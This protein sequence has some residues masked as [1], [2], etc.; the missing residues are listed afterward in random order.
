[1]ELE[2]KSFKI[3]NRQR[4]KTIKSKYKKLLIGARKNISQIEDLI[5]KK[6]K[7]EK[8][9]AQTSSRVKNIYSIHKKL[10]KTRNNY[11]KIQDLL[12]IRIIA[13][14]KEACY[15]I[16]GI[17]HTLYQPIPNRFSDYIALPK[18]NGYQSIHTIVR[19]NNNLPLEFQIRTTEMDY[20][21]NF[22][23]ASHFVYTDDLKPKEDKRKN[24]TYTPQKELKWI[25]ELA[26]WQEKIKDSSRFI[27]ELKIDFFNDRIFVFTPKGDVKDLPK[28]STPVDF[29]YS[30][31]T[32]IGN[33]A[34][35]AKID[36]ALKPLSYQLKDGETV[37]IL[38]RKNQKG[39]NPDWLEFVKSSGAKEKIRSKINTLKKID[40]YL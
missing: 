13:E 17:I 38:I 27:K 31:H 36:G 14:N 39:P 26:Q 18:L 9:F 30:V 20:Q 19:V 10:I 37:E 23:L 12:G 1:M 5:I 3:L 2:D 4:Y 32:E 40:Q 35:G 24:S 8:I 6:L 28:G 29:A 34:C 21:A 11:Q 25:H 33:K 15:K 16:L 7:K 22:V